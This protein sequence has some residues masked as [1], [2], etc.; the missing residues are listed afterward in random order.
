MRVFVVALL[1]TGACSGD[2]APHSE[3]S[4]S[5]MSRETTNYGSGIN[6]GST[7]GTPSLGSWP[8]APIAGG[9][10][11]NMDRAM[12]LGAVYLVDIYGKDTI[13]FPLSAKIKNGVWLVEDSGP[14]RGAIGGSRYVEICQ[15]NGAV[16]S[17]FETQ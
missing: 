12:A 10:V 4:S 2:I 3:N 16:L 6:K 17:T 7:C 13:R 9:I 11:K 1:L 14:G 5:L 8:P 15:S